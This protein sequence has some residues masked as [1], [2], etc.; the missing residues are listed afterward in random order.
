MHAIRKRSLFARYSKVHVP[1]I[2]TKTCPN[3]CSGNGVCNADTGLCD[4]PAGVSGPDCGAADPRPCTDKYRED[5]RSKLPASHIGANMRDLNWTASGWTSSRCA[6]VCDEATAVCYCDGPHF[7][8]IPAPEG[9]PPGSPPIRPGRLLHGH[10]QRLTTDDKGQQLNWGGSQRG[11][12]FEEIYGA[13]GWCTIDKPFVRCSCDMDGVDGKLCELVT[14]TVCPNQCSAHGICT[15]GYCQCFPGWYGLDCARLS[16]PSQLL[17]HA[18]HVSNS[19]ADSDARQSPGGADLAADLD[20]KGGSSE[21]GAAPEDAQA[22]PS[23]LQLPTHVQL[24]V[25]RPYLVNHYVDVPAIPSLYFTPLSAD[26]AESGAE[27]AAAAAVGD[28]GS[29]TREAIEQMHTSQARTLQGQSTGPDAL[30][31]QSQLKTG[32]QQQQQYSQLIMGEQV[33]SNAAASRSAEGG[34]G[35]HADGSSPELLQHS[36]SRRRALL[37]HFWTGG[38]SQRVA[39]SI[40]PSQEA[41]DAAVRSFLLDQGSGSNSSAVY[42]GDQL[43]AQLYEA[44]RQAGVRVDRLTSATDVAVLQHMVESSLGQPLP[45]G[46]GRRPKIFVYDMPSRF[47]GRLLQYRPSKQTCTWRVFSKS[48]YSMYTTSENEH[49]WRYPLE[50]HLHELMLQ[51]PHR[52]LDPEQADFFYV[53]VYAACFMEAVAGWADAPW[54]H[55]QS[56]SSVKQGVFMHL[57]ALNW[58]RTTYPYWNASNGANHIWLFAHDE[59]AC[60]A[61]TE[62]YNRSII[63][64]QWGRLAPP[65]YK[66]KNGPVTESLTSRWE[67]NYNKLEPLDDPLAPPGGYGAYITNHPCYT[68]GKDLVLPAFKPPTRYHASPFMGGSKSPD[69]DILLLLRGDLGASRPA[70]YSSGI[71]QQLA[72]LSKSGN[73][74]SKYRVWIGTEQELDG[75]YSVLLSRSRYC[76]VVP[77]DGWS[78]LLE[79]AV[80][81]GCIPVVVLLPGES[82]MAQ[83]FSAM[84]RLSSVVIKVSATQL[85][86]LPETLAGISKTEEADRR[87][88]L[89]RWWH[90]MAWLSHPWLQSQAHTMIQENLGRHPTVKDMLEEQHLQQ[91]AAKQKM[92]AK[93]KAADVDVMSSLDVAGDLLVVS[94]S[95][96]DST[97]DHAGDI[98]NTSALEAEKAVQEVSELFNVRIWQQDAPVDDAFAT[99]MQWLYYKMLHPYKAFSQSGMGPL[100]DVG[101]DVV[102]DTLKTK[103]QHT[104]PGGNMAIGTHAL[105]SSVITTE[106]RQ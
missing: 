97:P 101:A 79:D 93:A 27:A 60:W 24:L 98:T 63:L 31:R 20:P 52:T 26:E 53:P 67:Y 42:G 19:S 47:V 17:Q 56:E 29:L 4:C 16:D 76:L 37:R 66:S 8:R 30:P 49:S 83:P 68:P 5:R 104:R 90:R 89:S 11:M 78:G 7:G 80:L 95:S 33:R 106:R 59:G 39:M 9:A 100:R 91:Q 81:H 6:G 77:R 21:G 3:G 13:Q 36:T 82:S 15:R 61:P 32:N 69:R 48:N 72:K 50:S 2:H 105:G 28:A 44:L 92:G 99:L 65:A 34:D 51:S 55:T 38:G 86:Q 64:S 22:A 85:A 70:A 74:R 18:A 43:V 12:T 10:C 40:A 58:I 46:F 103:K 94:G 45:A 57:D 88:Q 73:W 75:D 23:P 35:S 87:A 41:V 54:W 62:I 14:E 1:R 71:R 25:D 96:G 84:L 102:D